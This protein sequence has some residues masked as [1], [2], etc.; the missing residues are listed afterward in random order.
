MQMAVETPETVSGRAKPAIGLNRCAV[1][2]QAGASSAC[3]SRSG[4]PRFE[5]TVPAGSPEGQYVI[6]AIG[7]RVSGP[8]AS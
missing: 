5:V 4:E 7:D 2:E 6:G 3:H 1:V 8:V